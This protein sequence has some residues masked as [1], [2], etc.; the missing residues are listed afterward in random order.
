MDKATLTSL[1]EDA[2]ALP[3]GS[4]ATDAMRES[5]GK[6]A[7]EHPYFGA[8]TLLQLRHMPEASD[9]EVEALR[10]RL[11]LQCPGR[12]TM[13][14]AAYGDDW[15]RFYPEAE[16]P[17]PQ[18][19]V[20]VI[21]TFLSTY[22]SCSPEEEALLERM[23][24]NPTPDYSEMLA[25]EE[26]ES[27]PEPDDA[28]ADSQDALINAFI[29]DRHPAAHSP[30]LMPEPAEAAAAEA[31]PERTPIPRPEHSDDTL[32]SESLAKIFIKQGRYERAYEII[33]GINLKF[34][35]KSAYF[36]DQ[37]RFLQ[38]LIMNRRRIEGLDDS[39]VT[40]K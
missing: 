1:L 38:K 23:I 10:R 8:L 29:R 32:L 27:L 5:L 21:D 36:A 35:K 7:G 31:E 9:E 39:G 11:A 34:P 6:A 20:D 33:S 4:A 3:D 37:L 40:E 15:A 24:F 28:P 2:L 25:R 26:Q 12:R 14:F 13:A 18:D 30:S 17:A 16:A 22:G 19:T